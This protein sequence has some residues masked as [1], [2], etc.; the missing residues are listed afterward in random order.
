M[1]TEKQ[2]LEMDLP[3]QVEMLLFRVSFKALTCLRYIIENINKSVLSI[4]SLFIKIPKQGCTMITKINE[5][6]NEPKHVF[7]RID[8]NRIES[9]VVPRLVLTSDT[10]MLLTEILIQKPWLGKS[11]NGKELEYDVDEQSWT[12]TRSHSSRM[13]GKVEGQAWLAIYQRKC[14]LWEHSFQ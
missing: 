1:P 12:E 14:R 4:F 3:N 8:F 10:P 13:I 11:K 2:T 9:S 6:C 7:A 5:P